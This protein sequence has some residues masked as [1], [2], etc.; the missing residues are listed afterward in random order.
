MNRQNLRP[1]LGETGSRGCAAPG[2]LHSPLLLRV[3]RFTGCP[4]GP[5]GARSGVHGVASRPGEVGAAGGPS[6]EA[7]VQ[8]GS[9]GSGGERLQRRRGPCED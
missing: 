3:A 6:L 7:A 8:V 4:G 2:A 5:L 9:Q 1:A